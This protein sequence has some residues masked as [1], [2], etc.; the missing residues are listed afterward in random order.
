MYKKSIKYLLS[1]IALL[2]KSKSLREIFF[3]YNKLRAF[4]VCITL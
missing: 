3:R 1:E 4:V 2:C